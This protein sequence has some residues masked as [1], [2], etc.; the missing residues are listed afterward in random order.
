MRETAVPSRPGAAWKVP[1]RSARRWGTPAAA[2]ILACGAIFALAAPPV[3]ADV[4]SGSGI[5]IARDAEIET[6]VQDYARPIFKAAGLRSGSVQIFLVPN[7]SFNAFVASG[8]TMFINVG[9]LIQSETP[10]EIIGVI[11]HETGHLV[12]GDLASLRQRIDEAKTAAMIAGLVGMG[13]AVAGSAAG[14]HGLGQAAGG[15]AL[16]ASQI[17]ERSV[18]AYQRSQESGADH[19]AAGFLEKTGQSGAGLLATFKRLADQMLLT[20]RSLDPY[21]QTHPL[22]EERVVALENLVTAGKFYDHKDPPELQKRH[23][24]MRAKLIGFTWTP[25]RILRR[26][27]MTDTSLPA[28]YARAISAYRSGALDPAIKQ[29][30]GLIAS[31]PSDAYFHELKGQA[32]LEGG[33]PKDSIAPLRKAVSL[34]P[35]AGLIRILLGQAL[36]SQN[37]PALVDEAVR[38]LARAYALRGDIPM[39]ELATAQGYFVNGEVK[40]AQMHAERAQAKLK[41]NSPAW[42]RADDIVSYKPPKTP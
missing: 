27:P 4:G 40:D 30:D 38:M 26:F 33:Q 23:D 15:I 8:Q 19:A 13:A 2:A 32:L 11:A 12:A 34:A 20:S 21:L 24:L 6:L 1:S 5:S 35:G 16:G 25:D 17:A 31:D 29:I 36:V 37:D 42:L 10:N 18:L 41:P 28:R 3:S 14:I 22:P 9:A 39:A 7:Q